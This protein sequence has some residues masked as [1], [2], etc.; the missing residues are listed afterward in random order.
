MNPSDF[1]PTDVVARLTGGV[2]NARHIAAGN[3]VL[4]DVKGTA[5]G[6]ARPDC[7]IRTEFPAQCGGDGADVKSCHEKKQELAG[8]LNESHIPVVH[9][10]LFGQVF[11]VQFD[12]RLT[13]GSAGLPV[14]RV[15]GMSAG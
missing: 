8:L 7:G 15:H 1:D 13:I 12:G 11:P 4:T 14:V 9:G 6:F 2:K 10:H 3:R 5:E